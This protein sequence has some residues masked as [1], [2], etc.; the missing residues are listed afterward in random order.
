MNPNETEWTPNRRQQAL[1]DALSTPPYPS[2]ATAL[3][4][5]KIPTG[6]GRRWHADDHFRAALVTATAADR[7]ILR[8][9]ATRRIGGMVDR[10]LTTKLLNLAS[11]SGAVRESAATWIL[12]RTLGKTPQTHEL[13]GPDGAPIEHR[14][15]GVWEE[16]LKEIYE[17][18]RRNL[19]EGHPD[20]PAGDESK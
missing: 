10:A 7:A 19:A 2:L 14:V 9:D 13:S 4:D 20:R 11:E 16:V 1:I 17:R 3:H 5:L 12:E 6:T 18:K 15:T 8:E